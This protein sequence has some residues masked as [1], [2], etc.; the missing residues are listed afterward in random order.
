[1]LI[2]CIFRFRSPGSAGILPAG[3]IFAAVFGAER[4]G[5]GD[6]APHSRAGLAA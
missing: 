4:A 3:G 6:I 5:N 2:A 1:M